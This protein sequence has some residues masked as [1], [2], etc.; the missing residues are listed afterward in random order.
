MGYTR[1]FLIC[2]FLFRFLELPP[3]QFA[4]QHALAES[5]YDKVD[6]NTFRTYCSLDAAELKR[7]K[8]SEFFK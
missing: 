7:Y 2:A 5:F 3:D 1:E 8:E 6:K 4:E